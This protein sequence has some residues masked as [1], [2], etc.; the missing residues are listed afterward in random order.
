MTEKNSFKN[1]MQSSSGSPEKWH[2][3]PS[4]EQKRSDALLYT[5]QKSTARLG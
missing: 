2:R 3:K 1:V 4:S 5:L